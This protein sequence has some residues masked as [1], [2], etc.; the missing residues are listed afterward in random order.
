MN[1]KKRNAYEIFLGKSRRKIPLG[2]S[3]C[4]WL[5]NIKIYLGEVEWCDM[6]WIDLAQDR[7]Q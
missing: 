6:D 4:R 2:R 1:G 3:R 7:D 5:D